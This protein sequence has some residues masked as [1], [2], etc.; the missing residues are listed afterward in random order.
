MFQFVRKMTPLSLFLF[1]LFLASCSTV[2][3]PEESGTSSEGSE[4]P[5][6]K[7]GVTVK[8][9]PMDEVLLK[10]YA[11]EPSL[12]VPKTYVPK[13]G[14]PV[15]DVHT[16]VY[17]TNPE[18]LDAW[19][20]TMDRVGI[21]VTVVLTGATGKRF[22]ELAELYLT[23]YPDRFQLYCGIDTEEIDDPGYPDRAVAEL[24][25]CYEKGARGV[26]EASDK[27]WGLDGNAD[28]HRPRGERLHPDDAR[29]APFWERCAE[30]SL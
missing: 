15:I 16:H 17:A 11:P 24:D 3:A 30:H 10:D 8:S 12:E 18:E 4:E 13:A 22:E 27:G 25:R 7:Y 2:S 28:S 26:G 29:L 9:G 20:N 19:V 1:L 14:F 5:V 6:V 23:R 21:D